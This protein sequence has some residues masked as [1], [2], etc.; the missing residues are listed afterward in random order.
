MKGKKLNS[1]EIDQLVAKIRSLYDD[2]MVKFIQGSRE[3]TGFE[4]RYFDAL[5]SRVNLQ[6]FLLVELKIVQQLIAREE[7]LQG[8]QEAEAYL[9]EKDLVGPN[10]RGG[11]KDVGAQAA[12]ES[13]EPQGDFADRVIEQMQRKAEKY[14][15]VGL[16][17]N[18]VWEVD[19]LFGGLQKFERELWPPV[20]RVYRKVY[21]SR[22]DGP[23]LMLETRLLELAE[24]RMGGVPQVL[25]TLQLLMGRFPRN[26]REIEWEKKHTILKASFFLHT[27]RGELEKL[28]QEAYLSE[29]DR[30]AVFN[31]NEF[32]NALIEDFRLKDLKE[33]EI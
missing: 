14:P 29:E 3:K 31:A 6:R 18:E 27:I 25:H 1:K 11:A 17:S 24:A 30:R 16:E 20:D 8:R 26:Y 5:K 32:V 10:G 21:P 23:R 28:R 33:K 19:H 12:E 4:Q 15:P 7:L 9:R 13:E 22:Y 2:Y